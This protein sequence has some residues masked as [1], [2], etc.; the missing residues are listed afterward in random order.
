MVPAMVK[1]HT[2]H[3]Q[4]GGHAWERPAQRGRPPHSCPEHPAPVEGACV[5]AHASKLDIL[6]ERAMDTLDGMREETRRKAEYLI[7]QA[8]DNARA[9]RED[10]D[11][12]LIEI[13]LN[14]ILA[15]RS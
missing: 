9:M 7:C 8:L 11:L 10:A 15:G 2:L 13:S 3:C 5:E 14:R 1:T 12:D 6:A 4:N